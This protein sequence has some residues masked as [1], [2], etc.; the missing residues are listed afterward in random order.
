[1]FNRKNCKEL[2]VACGID[3]QT[4]I[5]ISIVTN[6][7]SFTDNYWICLASHNILWK[8]INLHRNDFSLDIP[9]ISLTGDLK[10][11]VEKVYT[12]ELS[13]KGIRAK[14]IQNT[15]HYFVTASTFA[16]AKENI[17]QSM[18]TSIYNTLLLAKN[19]FQNR[20]FIDFFQ[21][22]KSEKHYYEMMTRLESLT[23]K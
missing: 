18:T 14:G 2:L 3:D 20:S 19:D 10:T 23:G 15:A 9:Q 1:M 21:N 13:V 12:G 7:L 16:T 6:A 11:I 8:E 4:P 5:N 22:Y 17:R